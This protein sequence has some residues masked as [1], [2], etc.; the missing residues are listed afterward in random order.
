MMRNQPVKPWTETR[1]ALI[2]GCV[3]LF[4]ALQG[5]L[6]PLAAVAHAAHPVDGASVSSLV[7]SE[8]CHKGDAGDPSERA[9]HNPHDCCILC[10]V[11]ARDAA[12]VAVAASAWIA[13][14]LMRDAAP[15]AAVYPEPKDARPKSAGWASS[16][17]SR[18]PP[19]FS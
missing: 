6:A 7:D 8:I 17:S 9:R 10:Q 5:L 18:A 2:A 16:W 3:A 14:A 15:R 1:G 13:C 12:F 11:H 4:L 19:F